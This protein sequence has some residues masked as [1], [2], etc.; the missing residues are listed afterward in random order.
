MAELGKL[1]VFSNAVNGR[2]QEFNRWYSEV[3]IPD[4]L[5]AAPEIKSATRYSLSTIAMPE[6]Q[7]GWQFM[8][9]YAVSAEHLPG[10]LERMNTAMTNGEFEMSDAAEATS[11]A[12][13][14]ASEM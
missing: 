9:V 4:V 14:Y 5:R 13:F 7:S 1:V 6:G 8:T 10:V 3:H 11:S 12:L 2:E